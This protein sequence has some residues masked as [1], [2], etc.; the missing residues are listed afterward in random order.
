MSF[1]CARCGATQAG[2]PIKIIVEKR[3]KI[4]PMRR[5]NPLDVKSKII[6]NGG[7]GWEIAKE[8]TVCEKCK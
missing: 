6:D 8:I 7:A 2:K 3:E 5:E 4:Y 1:K